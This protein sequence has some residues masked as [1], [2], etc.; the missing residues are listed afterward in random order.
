MWSAPHEC[1]LQGGATAEA[2]T[3]M[4]VCHS[5]HVAAAY[6]HP[7]LPVT[8]W[9]STALIWLLEPVDFCPLL[10]QN[11]TSPC[12]IQAP[13]IHT[14]EPPCSMSPLCTMLLPTSLPL[15]LL[16]LLSG[17][18]LLPLPFTPT[19]AHMYA[20]TYLWVTPTCHLR[21]N[22]SLPPP[23]SLSSCVWTRVRVLCQSCL[24]SLS[25]RP[26][27]SVWGRSHSSVSPST[28]QGAWS[29]KMFSKQLNDSVKARDPLW[30]RKDF[31]CPTC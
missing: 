22:S 18:P 29:H 30:S 11:A 10:K 2:L 27:S 21:L 20:H 17:M 1:W 23:R 24:V 5:V 31:Q 15:L 25:H 13:R 4:H 3:E 6:A 8:L 26:V 9:N 16:Y 12:I 14:P 28:Q 19:C 7:R